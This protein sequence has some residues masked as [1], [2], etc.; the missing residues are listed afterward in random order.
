VLFRSIPE[1]VVNACNTIANE[2]CD[3][4][5]FVQIRRLLDRF[6]ARLLIR[7]MLVEGM[8]ASVPPEETGSTIGLRWVVLI[9]EET[10]RIRTEDVDLETPSQQLPVRLRNTIAHE[11]V[12]SL[13]FRP[14][15]FGI[16]LNVTST[17]QKPADLVHIV[18][19]ETERLSPLLL[20]PER[21]LTTLLQGKQEPLSLAQLVEARR[22]LG[23]SRYLL[24]NRLCLIRHSDDNG[25]LTSRGLRNLAIGL[26][27]WQADGMAVTRSWPLFANFDRNLLP[28]L[29]RKISRQD[30]LPA[31]SIFPDV[32]FA[33]CGGSNEKVTLSAP[34]GTEGNPEVERL[35]VEVS[36]ESTA[37]VA[38]SEFLFVVRVPLSSH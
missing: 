6:D 8:L 24:I 23:I 7:P 12:H 33:M 19:Q 21:A 17:R 16:S 2:V 29:L 27:E 38:G 28:A 25:H 4:S 9:D 36:A 26:A 34:A 18:E 15:E 13:A 11:L 22:A 14:T 5:G 31:K 20:W 3:A 30:R 32:T 10:Y 37:R 35:D 1:Q